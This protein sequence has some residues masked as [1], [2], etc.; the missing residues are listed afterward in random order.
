MTNDLP[1]Q[2]P[3]D[4][5]VA[6]PLPPEAGFTAWEIWAWERVIRGEL[7]DMSR[8]PGAADEQ[9]VNPSNAASWPAHRVLSERFLRTILFHEPWSTAP[10]R[11]GARIRCAIIKEAINWSARRSHG[12]IWLDLC[13]FEQPVTLQDA[14]F[15]GLLSL[16][17]SVFQGVLDLERAYVQGGLLL[18]GIRAQQE[19]RMLGAK[20]GGT[21]SL[22]EAILNA[23]VKAD[24]IDVGGS[25]FFRDTT[26]MAEIIMVGAIVR[27][28]LSFV[29]A[30][31]NGF[32]QLEGVHVEGDL[33]LRGMKK[34]STASMIGM[35]ID[36]DLQ[37]CGTYVD[38]DIVLTGSRIDGELHLEGPGVDPPIWSERSKFV[39]RNVECA[40]LA[41]SLR[42]F[43]T[44]RGKGRKR[45]VAMDLA[46][47]KYRRMGGFGGDTGATLAEASSDDLVAWL[48][49]ATPADARFNPQP[50][51]HLGATLIDA[52]HRNKADD[53]MFA[54][55]HHEL[56]ASTTAVGRRVALF[57]SWL[58]I[59]YGYR[60]FAAVLWFLGAVVLGAALGLGTLGFHGVTPPP[61]PAEMSRWGWFSFGNAIPVLTLDE[62]HKTFIADTFRAKG[63]LEPTWLKSFF[64]V[65]K[66]FGF[67]MLTYL[68]AGLS[69]MAGRARE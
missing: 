22:R 17:G 2:R 16:E 68:A 58:F 50:Y 45:F 24:R 34:L 48:H 61:P 1:R 13:L 62:A 6:A 43:Q 38:G 30:E 55:H 23:A 67:A 47:F 32:L 60:N 65:Q 40:A 19:I 10:E 3:W 51:R 29:G 36:L 56:G 5:G 41:G 39:L 25:M 35:K 28:Q 69:G 42:A 33:F 53:V 9:D 26:C 20:V 54:L 52:G 49:R 27:G 8:Y 18:S 63:L 64:Y 7:A 15:C 31:L 57:F 66:L 11:P 46:G 14:T 37:L 12:E 4:E 21:L 59:G 44:E